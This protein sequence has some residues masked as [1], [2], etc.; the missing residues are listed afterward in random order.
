M[1][2]LDVT[3]G[4]AA[5]AGETVIAVGESWESLGR[6]SRNGSLGARWKGRKPVVGGQGLS[7]FGESGM[8]LETGQRVSLGCLLAGGERFNVAVS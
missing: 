4:V 3:G 5:F 1:G 8:L 7:R 2:E 6:A